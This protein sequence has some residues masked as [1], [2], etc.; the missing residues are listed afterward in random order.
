[1]VVNWLRKKKKTNKNKDKQRQRQQKT[2]TK[3][4]TRDELRR[5]IKPNFFYV[6]FVHVQPSFYSL[7]TFVLSGKMEDR[8]RRPM[9][10]GL[11]VSERI[12]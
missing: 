11:S 6:F 9:T 8:L 1:M 12:R 3:K 10:A 2:K 7:T 5:K 4:A